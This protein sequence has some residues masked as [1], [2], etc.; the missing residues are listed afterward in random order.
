MQTSS[1]PFRAGSCTEDGNQAEETGQ[2][3]LQW[4]ETDQNV[5]FG[6]DEQQKSERLGCRS[7]PRLSKRERAC[8][9]EHFSRRQSESLS[10][11]LLV[12]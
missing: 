5:L 11:N 1:T 9:S 10:Y 2:M 3:H 12:L 8:S 4:T 6:Q 7:V